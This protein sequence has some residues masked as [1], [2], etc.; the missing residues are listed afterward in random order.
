MLAVERV[1]K[2]LLYIDELTGF[3]NYR[4]LRCRPGKGKRN[5]RYSLNISVI[6]LDIDLFKRVNDQCGH[7]VGSKSL[8]EVGLLLKKSV[9]DV[10]TLIRYGG[11][12]YTIILV[13][14]GITGAAAVAERIR[15]SIENHVFNRS[16]GLE[17][18]LTA[19][20]GYACY[21]QDASSKIQL[22]ELADQAMYRSKADGKN[23]VFYIGARNSKSGQGDQQ[24]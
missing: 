3:F 2:N 4:F 13:E 12:E 17:I 5:K 21:P 9:R 15:G 6:F 1:P 16:D 22:L 19:S 7:L 23:R 24:A 18:K 8:A 11:D 10:D 14:T 20:L